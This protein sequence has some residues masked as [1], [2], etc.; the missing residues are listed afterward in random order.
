MREDIDSKDSEKSVEKK[1]TTLLSVENAESAM[2]FFTCLTLIVVISLYIYL[3]YAKNKSF[4]EA[5]II[6]IENNPKI[7]AGVTISLVIKEGI[8]IMLLK[9]VR[10]YLDERKQAL[11]KAKKEAYD[12]GY[13]DAQK[14]FRNKNGKIS[15]TSTKKK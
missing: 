9:R 1:R 10:K 15:S 5:L 8:D 14:E 4:W 6:I 11:E 12:K 3:K 13:S 7:L 2:A